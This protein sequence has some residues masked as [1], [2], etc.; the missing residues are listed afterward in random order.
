MQEQVLTFC[1]VCGAHCSARATV[2]NGKLLKWEQDKESGFAY[3]PCTS[4]KGLANKEINEHPDRLKYPLKRI[5]ERGAGKWERISWDEALNTIAEKLLQLKE[6]Y[7]PECLGMSVGEPKLFEFVWL[8]RLATAFGTPNIASPHHICGATRFASASITF[9]PHHSPDPFT[10]HLDRS[11]IDKED[12]PRLLVIWG[13]AMVEKVGSERDW[14]N[15]VVQNGGK[16]IVIDPRRLAICK[17]ADLWIRPRPGSDAALAMGMLKVIIEEK[18]YDEDFVRN[19]T[20]GFDKLCDEIK[21]FTIEDVEKKT[22]VPREQIEQLARWYGTYKPATLLGRGNTWSQGTRN[23]QGMRI[24]QILRAIVTPENIPGWNYSFSRLPQNTP[25]HMYLLDRLKRPLEGNVG[26]RHKYTV[27]TS[28]I[29]YQSL[30]KGI[31]D[32]I[33]KAAIFTQCDPIISYPNAR[34]VYDAFMKLDLNVVMN[35]FM[36]PTATIADIV[37]PVATANECDTIACF[38]GAQVFRA[39]P[40]I[41]DPPGEAWSDI[42]IINELGKRLGLTQYFFDTDEEVLNFALEPSGL[43]WQDFKTKVRMFQPEREYRKE[44]SGF[45]T[46]P[47]GKV[48]IYSQRAV[49]EYGCDPLPT[50]KH[51]SEIPDATKEYPLLLTNYCD[52]QYKLTGFKHVQYFRKRKPFPTVQLNPDT[53]KKAG[54]KDGDWA[55]I[56][57]KLGRISQ[58]VVID[59]D[60]DPR[61]VMAS[62]GWWFPETPANSNQ[63]DRSNINILI[64]DD[65]A[66]KATG[67]VDLRGIPCKVYKGEMSP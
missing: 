20:V 38:T 28:F 4:F 42:K 58:Q 37:L 25:R 19:Y 57:T 49:E 55:Y 21:K 32:G 23:F 30:T 15:A 33:V 26:S 14:V 24:I 34:K 51:V 46:T 8:Q 61:V 11:A 7:G 64:E 27:K 9:G 60:L 31:L 54:V 53:A 66:E 50:W 52:E 10:E 41:V 59:P 39:L 6:K 36:V 3:R 65:E 63:W 2:E 43:T 17:K 1:A 40:K 56:E 18:L 45:F 44:K 5:G 47:S 22:W 13:Y 62:F 35:I 29:P 48:E 67:S 16:L 12:L